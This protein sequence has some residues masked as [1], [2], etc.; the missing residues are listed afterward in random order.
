MELAPPVADLPPAEL[1]FSEQL[2]TI[3][4][5]L[6]RQDQMSVETLAEHL[7][8]SPRSLQRKLHSLFG[9]SYT[10]YARE[11]QLQLVVEQLQRGAS[12]KEAAAAT[13]FCD[14]AYLTRVFKQQFGVTPS[15]YKKQQHV[16]SESEG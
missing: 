1:L 9:L 11:L 8:M 3:S 12:V 5:Q 7:Q 2:R 16:R 10:D 13:G 6:L 4:C 14:Q 15:Q